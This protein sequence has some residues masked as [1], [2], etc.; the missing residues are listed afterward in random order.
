TSFVGHGA[1]LRAHHGRTGAGADL[2]PRMLERLAALVRELP[3]LTGEERAAA[4]QAI[5]AA[6]SR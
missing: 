1:G 3:E 5:S 4:L 2:V 6:A